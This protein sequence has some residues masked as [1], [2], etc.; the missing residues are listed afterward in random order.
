LVSFSKRK[1][2]PNESAVKPGVKVMLSLTQIEQRLQLAADVDI[3]RGTFKTL[4][5]GVSL[6]Q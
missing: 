1:I 3:Q 4:T 2:A 5:D 6:I